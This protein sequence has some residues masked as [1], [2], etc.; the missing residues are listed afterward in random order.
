MNNHTNVEENQIAENISDRNNQILG[1]RQPINTLEQLT[2]H[3]QVG[4]LLLLSPENEN[5]PPPPLDV[6]SLPNVWIYDGG[7]YDL[8][9]FIAK[10]PGGQFFIRRT[11]NRDITTFVNFFH[12]NPEKVRK[13][14]E[15]YSLG[16][17]ATLQDVHP[18]CW[19]PKFLF[20]QDFDS[21]RDTPKYNFKKD[22]Q[23]LDRIRARLNK[24]EMKEKVAQMDFLF[25]LVSIMLV[26]GYVLIEWL[27]LDFKQYMPIYIFIPLMAMVKISLSGVGHYIL[28]RPQIGLNKIFAHAF[29]INYVPLAIVQ[30][31]GHNLMHHPFIESKADVKKNGT[32]SFFL[33]LPRYYRIPLHTL[34]IIAHVISGMFAQI[35]IVAIL[36][37]QGIIKERNPEGKGIIWPLGFPIES[38]V[39]AFGIHLL[40]LGELILFTLKGDFIAWVGQ[41]LLTLWV[42][43]FLILAS[44]DFAEATTEEETNW[45]EKDWAVLQIENSRDLSIIGNKYIDSFLSAGLSPHRVHHVLPQQKSA[46]ANIISEDIVREEAAKFNVEWLQPKNLFF[47]WLPSL[48]NQYL[49]A[50]SVMAKENKLGLFKEHFHPQALKL[51][52]N[53]II[54]GFIGFS[55]I[56]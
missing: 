36:S 2:L 33:E 31:D 16:G 53:Y 22:E 25:N 6:T 9:E 26:I 41:F 38:F 28:H 40:M 56:G 14:L 46:F 19:A 43:T 34:H 30:I 23:L 29:D 42:T 18:T 24:S 51:S 37:I 50:P 21:W 8:T 17:P 1:D 44:P 11:K 4:D 48:I 5:E 49:A 12:S 54:S 7:A 35:T 45:E 10:H 27:R 20:S 55:G 32:V 39:G 47:D 13:V 52:V 15:K 3:N